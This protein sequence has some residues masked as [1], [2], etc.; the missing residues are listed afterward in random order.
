MT[1]ATVT[2]K[3]QVTIPA[4]IRA[5]FEIK[6]GD[7]IVF[8]KKLG[9]ELVCISAGPR[10]GRVGAFLPAR[11]PRWRWRKWSPLGRHEV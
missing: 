6:A 10:L 9:G 8:F 5:D 4:D 11:L 2:S 1:I 7:Q 3:G